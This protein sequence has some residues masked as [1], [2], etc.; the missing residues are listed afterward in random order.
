MTTAAEDRYRMNRTCDACNAPAVWH[1]HHDGREIL[2]CG[3]HFHGA[4]IKLLMDGFQVENVSV[5][6]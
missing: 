2:L 4:R 5:G 6:V 3:H 1:A